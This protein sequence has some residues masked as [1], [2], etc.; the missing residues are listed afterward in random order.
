MQTGELNP[1]TLAVLGLVLLGAL[2]FGYWKMLYTPAVQ[3]KASAQMMKEQADKALAD[4]RTQLAEAEA[5]ADVGT[6]ADPDAVAEIQNMKLA[7]PR[8]EAIELASIELRTLAK[9]NG[10][11]VTS[12]KAG[13]E[14]SG[15]LSVT[16]EVD[17]ATGEPSGGSKAVPST[18]KIQGHARFTGILLYV[19]AIQRQVQA[20]GGKLYISGRLMEITTL[21]V[22]KSDEDSGA[23]EDFSA[24]VTAGED[25][26]QAS[27]PAG[28]HAFTIVVRMYAERVPG[29]GSGAS[30][31]DGETP[32]EGATPDE[33]GAAADANATQ[34]PA[35]G[36]AQTGAADST[37]TADTGAAEPTASGAATPGASA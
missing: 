21:T 4:A 19:N 5:G 25:E 26:T 16:E 31:G 32:E 22:G 12:L 8:T 13:E 23:T 24:G 36:N 9:R 37:G 35:A 33:S 34:D 28:H 3:G 29:T 1:K 10:A 17:P 15:G 7:V 30:A 2:G 18:I 27:L 14:D 6:A 11:V 20:N